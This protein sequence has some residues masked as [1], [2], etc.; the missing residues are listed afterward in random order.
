MLH[1]TQSLVVDS[2]VPQTILAN[3]PAA[4]DA[5]RL[6]GLRP[7]TDQPGLRPDQPGP[8]LTTD[9]PMFMKER[10]F[11]R[12][13]FFQ[14]FLMTLS[15]CY[16][17]TSLRLHSSERRHMSITLSHIGSPSCYATRPSTVGTTHPA[18][19]DEPHHGTGKMAPPTMLPAEGL[20]FLS[21]FTS[22]D[23]G[24]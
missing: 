10:R 3:I 16:I 18:T 5:V 22:L 23:K 2:K 6:P 7:S 9:Q 17:A 1:R 8:R 24:T 14:C 21:W 15:I 20:K 11:Q 4:T 13:F 12:K 19:R